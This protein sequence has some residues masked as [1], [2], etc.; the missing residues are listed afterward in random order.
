MT[1]S[2]PA[3]EW[4]V[5]ERV[6]PYMDQTLGVDR[7][8]EVRHRETSAMRVVMLTR[9]TPGRWSQPPQWLCTCG[10]ASPGRPCEHV[11]AVQATLPPVAA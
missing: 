4:R 10:L 7:R 9:R 6:V 8:W 2:V 5:E 3:P 1:V 11:R